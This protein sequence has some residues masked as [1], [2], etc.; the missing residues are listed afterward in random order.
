MKLKALAKL[1]SGQLAGD[2]EVNIARVAQI[3]DA[4]LGDLVFVLEEKLLAKALNS[5]ASALLA[6]K[7]IGPVKK[8]A[9]LVENPRLAMAEILPLFASMKSPKIAIHKTTIIPQ[10]C[11]IGK[12]VT[13]GAYT[14]LGENVQ[15]G[16]NSIIHPNVTIY[17]NVTIGKRVIIHAGSRIGVDGYGYVQQNGKHIKIPQIG[18]VIIEDDVELY[19]NVCISRGTMG[20][21]IIGA[22]TKIDSLTHIAHNCIIGKDC[23]MVSLVGM[24]GSVKLG[25]RVFVGGQAG[26]NGHISIGENTIIMARSGVTKD[27]PPNSIVSGF[28]AID[29]RA[30]MANLAALRRFAK[31]NRCE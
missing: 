19:A 20:P 22:G 26:F 23:A 1:I 31:K 15:I 3:E 24:A 8:P 25:D 4:Q 27:I 9:L 2:G 5:P 18:S 6:S 30:D 16:E 28:P 10:S 7:K 17:D 11:R 12:K 14:V 13:I 21:T 29:H